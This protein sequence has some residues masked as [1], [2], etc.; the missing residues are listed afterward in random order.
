M[1][2]ERQIAKH[3]VVRKFALIAKSKLQSKFQ[4][5]LIHIKIGNYPATSDAM[6]AC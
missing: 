2:T 3:Y 5:E 1:Q 4:I 6:R